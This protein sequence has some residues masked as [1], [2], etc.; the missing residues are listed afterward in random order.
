MT[1]TVKEV[2]PPC[3]LLGVTL[4]YINCSCS[5]DLAATQGIQSDGDLSA[6]TFMIIKA[7]L[8][9]DY[10]AILIDDYK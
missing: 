2:N 10:A 5:F 9:W 7:I 8:I 1:K 3:H 4:F 6:L